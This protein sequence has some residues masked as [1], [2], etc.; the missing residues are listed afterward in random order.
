M[1]NAF[2]AGCDAY[3]PR[4]YSLAIESLVTAV[5]HLI[6]KSGLGSIIIEYRSH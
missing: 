3:M 4:H 5:I 2:L 1:T 6:M